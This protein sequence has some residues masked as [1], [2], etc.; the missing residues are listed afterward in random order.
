[1]VPVII[2]LF[3][4]WFF[5]VFCGYMFGIVFGLGLAGMWF[6]FA[7]DECSRGAVL[8]L[9]WRTQK[10]KKRMLIKNPVNIS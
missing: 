10:W 8:C 5:A 3:C 7:L 6:A 2:E 9:R 4:M 1:V